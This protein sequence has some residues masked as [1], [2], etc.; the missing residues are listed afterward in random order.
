MGVVWAD[1]RGVVGGGGEGWG[2]GMGW[3]ESEVC[4]MC[5]KGLLFY[6]ILLNEKWILSLPYI[7]IRHSHTH[8]NYSL[9]PPDPPSQQ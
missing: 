2:W 3:D 1:G 8:H 9:Y 6:S 5:V 7:V 4:Q